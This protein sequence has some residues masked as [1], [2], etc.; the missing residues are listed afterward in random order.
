MSKLSEIKDRLAKELGF[1]DGDP[2]FKSMEEAML[3][4]PGYAES[5]I[6]HIWSS[7]YEIG[8]TSKPP[9]GVTQWKNEG[10]KYHYDKYYKIKW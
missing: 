3:F 7:A 1:K 8:K 6:E 2:S 5:V 4:C 10:M 9:Q